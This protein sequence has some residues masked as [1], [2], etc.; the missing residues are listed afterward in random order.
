MDSYT[1]AE[2]SDAA[3]IE[4]LLPSIKRHVVNIP[5][6]MQQLQI[7]DS[8]IF[9]KKE[10]RHRFL[11]PCIR[12]VFLVCILLMVGMGVLML[13]RNI[14]ESVKRIMETEI[15][16]FGWNPSVNDVTRDPK[17]TTPEYS[18]NRKEL[19]TAMPKPHYTILYSMYNPHS[20]LYSPVLIS[21]IYIAR[22]GQTT[23]SFGFPSG[24]ISTIYIGNISVKNSVGQELLVNG[25]F[26]SGTYGWQGVSYIS[27]CGYSFDYENC[28]RTDFKV[29][30][31]LSQ[32]FSTTPG[33]V[34]YITFKLRWTGSSSN[35]G[36]N[37]TIY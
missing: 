4:T 3:P 17:T 37:A 14:K 18:W 6:D 22:A 11:T 20:S 27:G 13:P 32:T 2:K 12:Y 15:I 29:G 31:T 9:I 10:R 21:S 5:K 7:K 19:S 26:T 16:N 30:D 25:N 35:D 34:L 24:V 36:L 8:T 28:F 33:T 23:L 1:F